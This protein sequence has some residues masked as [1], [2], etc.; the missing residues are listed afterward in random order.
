V[1]FVLISVTNATQSE[2]EVY[3]DF[4]NNCQTS[5]SDSTQFISFKFLAIIISLVYVFF[6]VIV[7]MVVMINSFV[8]NLK[9][10]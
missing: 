4:V 2:L 9:T 1:I 6:P 3:L 5:N 10:F 8:C 7:I